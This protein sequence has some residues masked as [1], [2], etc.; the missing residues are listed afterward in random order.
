[1]A[2]TYDIKVMIPSNIQ[3]IFNR[4]SDTLDRMHK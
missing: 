1:M 3:K 4:Q 2:L